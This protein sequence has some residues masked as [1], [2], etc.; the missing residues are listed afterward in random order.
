LE[1]EEAYLILTPRANEIEKMAVVV[2]QQY[3]YRQRMKD[4]E[5]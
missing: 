3:E 5:A 1:V 4:G 2:L